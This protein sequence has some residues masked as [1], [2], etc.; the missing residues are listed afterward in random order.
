MT[1]PY[2]SPYGGAGEQPATIPITAP[3]TEIMS[4]LI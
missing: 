1:M 4:F 2:Q 3:N